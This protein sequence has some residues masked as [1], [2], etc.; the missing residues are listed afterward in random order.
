MGD[1]LYKIGL[2]FEE[3]DLQDNANVFNS[4]VFLRVVKMQGSGVRV[5]DEIDCYVYE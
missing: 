3:H 1:A 4:L 2:I 5:C